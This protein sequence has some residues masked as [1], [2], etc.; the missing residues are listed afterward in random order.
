MKFMSVMVDDADFGRRRFDR[1]VGSLAEVAQ[2]K[3]RVDR[4]YAA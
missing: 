2:Q 1:D 3:V 4:K